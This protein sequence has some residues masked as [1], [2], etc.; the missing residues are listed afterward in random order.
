ML[1]IALSEEV[2]KTA[3]DIGASAAALICEGTIITARVALAKKRLDKKGCKNAVNAAF[4][5]AADHA[6]EL[7]VAVK[8]RVLKFLHDEGMSM[9]LDT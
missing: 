8:E 6:T 9:V 5:K 2:V 7:G 3:K 4:D 1:N